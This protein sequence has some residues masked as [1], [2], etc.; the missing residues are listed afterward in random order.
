MK[1]DICMVNKER[2]EF[3]MKTQKEKKVHVCNEN[4][5]VKKSER[6]ECLFAMKTE[7]D[8]NVMS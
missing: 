4:T 5:T 7:K 6:E 1:S 8:T 2:E 3:A